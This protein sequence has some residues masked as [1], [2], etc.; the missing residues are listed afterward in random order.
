MADDKRQVPP[1][2]EGFKDIPVTKAI[3]FVKPKDGEDL[4][5]RFLEPV[6]P[7]SLG[8]LKFDM[9]GAPGTMTPEQ[10]RDFL[11]AQRYDAWLASA[12]E[13]MSQVEPYTGP[14]TIAALQRTPKK[15]QDHVPDQ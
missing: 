11:G 7:D 6:D 9:L 8:F 4:V 3:E 14:K 13:D 12:D 5:V 2:P 1:M 10:A 15:E